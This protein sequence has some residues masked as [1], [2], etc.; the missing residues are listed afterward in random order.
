MI[1]VTNH[2]LEVVREKQWK[3]KEMVEKRKTKAIAARRQRIRG[4]ISLSSE[5]KENYERDI[6]DKTDPDQIG[7]DK[8]PLQLSEGRVRGSNK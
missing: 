2:R 4:G 7:N 8:N 1:R 3:W 6:K 5:K